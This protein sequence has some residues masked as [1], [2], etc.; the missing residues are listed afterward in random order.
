MLT[1]ICCWWYLGNSLDLSA[2]H[3]FDDHFK[4]P[5]L[6]YCNEFVTCTTVLGGGYIKE[7]HLSCAS[8]GVCLIW[9]LQTEAPRRSSSPFHIISRQKHHTV[10]ISEAFIANM[11]QLQEHSHLSSS[12][13]PSGC[14]YSKQQ[15]LTLPFSG[16]PGC[17]YQNNLSNI[18]TAALQAECLTTALPATAVGQASGLSIVYCCHGNWILK[19]WLT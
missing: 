5:L 1:S 12:Y 15:P 13:K 11:T 18:I 17:F 2:S 3:Y 8:S 7:F 19:K 4:V 14:W 16:H 9:C 6:S 10:V